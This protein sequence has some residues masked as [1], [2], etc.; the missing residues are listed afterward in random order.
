M[1][2]GFHG[3][4][5]DGD[6]LGDEADDVLGVVGAVG[7][8]GDA[9]ALVGADLVL[10]NDPVQGGAVAETVFKGLGRDAFEGKEVVID[11]GG[12]GGGGRGQSLVI[13]NRWRAASGR[14]L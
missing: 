3:F 14:S 4:E 10:V 1:L 12:G 8:V 9:A 13:S 6:D 5:A 7:V 11:D 2:D